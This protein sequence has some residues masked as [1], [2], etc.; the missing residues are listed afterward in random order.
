MPENI[1][2]STRLKKVATGLSFAAIARAMDWSN[3]G[4]YIGE[5]VASFLT[6]RGLADIPHVFMA[7]HSMG[8]RN[9]QIVE[10]REPAYYEEACFNG[11]WYILTEEDATYLYCDS[12]TS[13]SSLTAVK[14][15]DGSWTLSL[16]VPIEEDGQPYQGS[17]WGVFHNVVENGAVWMSPREL[18]EAEMIAAA[19]GPGEWEAAGDG[20]WEKNLPDGRRLR[21]EAETPPTSDETG[22]ISGR[23]SIVKQEVCRQSRW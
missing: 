15:Y 19:N 22:P 13:G 23:L 17:Y 16:E 1:A 7:T 8:G 14:Q 11:G 6:E 18:A 20:I 2:V 9:W 12:A 3:V 10:G 4:S 5:E 21:I